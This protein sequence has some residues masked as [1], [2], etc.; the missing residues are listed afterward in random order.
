MP[1]T[2]PTAPRSKRTPDVSAPMVPTLLPERFK[3]IGSAPGEVPLHAPAAREE[4]SLGEQ[5]ALSLL[6]VTAEP[7]P[8]EDAPGELPFGCCKPYFC[9]SERRVASAAASRRND[10]VPWITSAQFAAYWEL[11]SFPIACVIA[12]VVRQV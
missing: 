10:A 4:P 9:A 6:G 8:P 3:T 12:S 1:C 7:E 11:R 2:V 5:A